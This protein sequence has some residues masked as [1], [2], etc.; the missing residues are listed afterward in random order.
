MSDI[1]DEFFEEDHAK[2]RHAV[3]Q[4]A[5]ASRSFRKGR[6][7]RHYSRRKKIARQKFYIERAGGIWCDH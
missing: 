7:R 3:K 2:Q 5:V 6:R 1:I 4:G